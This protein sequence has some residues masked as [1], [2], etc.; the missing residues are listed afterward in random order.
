MGL[1]VARRTV[2]V[3]QVIGELERQVHSGSWALGERLPSET[4]LAEELGVGRSTVREAVRALISSGLLE[5]RQGAG[6]YVR[7]LAPRAAD[8][9][10]RLRRAGVLEVYEVRHGLEMLAARLAAARCTDD[11]VL[12]LE[13]AL[14]RRRRARSAGRIKAF[15]DADLDFHRGV[16]AA[17]H[18][19]VLTDLFDAFLDVLRG[20]LLDLAG[21]PVLRQD[22]HPQHIALAQAI[23]RGDQDA[24][25]EATA[26][27]LHRTEEKLSQLLERLA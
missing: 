19:P 25:A 14:T 9:P 22:T 21:D 5:S 24:A 15:V 27:H 3:E 1:T 7:A 6:T 20:A 12:R 10:A 4:Q 2:L 26:D 11:D 23:R 8:L 17:A 13:A 16:V 18:N